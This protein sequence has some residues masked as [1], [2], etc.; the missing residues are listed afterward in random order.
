RAHQRRAWRA[1]SGQ[2]LLRSVP[3]AVEQREDDS[4]AQAALAD[5][6]RLAEH[7]RELLEQQHSG[8]KQ[9]DAARVELEALGAL[10]DLV[11]REHADRALEGLVLEHR[12]DQSAQRRGAAAYRHRLVRIHQ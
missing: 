7:L 2:L 11:A 8:R 12:P 6:Q 10:V 1:L 9:L 5:L 3:V 4:L